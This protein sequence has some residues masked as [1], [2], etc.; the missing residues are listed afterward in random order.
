MD[1]GRPSNF[2][3]VEYRENL[4]MASAKILDFLRRLKSFESKLKSFHKVMTE[5][6]K[7]N[8]GC[9]R[10]LNLADTLVWDPD[11]GYA[12][13]LLVGAPIFQLENFQ[14]IIPET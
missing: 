9:Y 2:F 4:K 13:Y 14:I 12:R 3:L 5:K 6:V 1:S 7:T 8:I 11:S 10:F